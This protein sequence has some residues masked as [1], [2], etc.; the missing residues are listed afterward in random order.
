MHDELFVMARKDASPI[1]SSCRSKLS[2]ASDTRPLCKLNGVGRVP[3]GVG[4]ACCQADVRRRGR[5]AVD[6]VEAEAERANKKSSNRSKPG[7]I[8]FEGQSAS[9]TESDVHALDLEESTARQMRVGVSSSLV[10][11][12]SSS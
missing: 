12:W 5:S 6:Q 1:E 2:L 10:R 4:Q 11:F 9:S 8:P 7:S 3:N